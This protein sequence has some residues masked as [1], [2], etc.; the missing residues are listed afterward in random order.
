MVSV[1]ILARENRVMIDAIKDDISSI[2]TEMKN[3]GNHYSKRI[4]AWAS[5]LFMILTA[6]I[7]GMVGRVL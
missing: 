1:N 7:G 3:I 2:K 6:I 5:V 4:P